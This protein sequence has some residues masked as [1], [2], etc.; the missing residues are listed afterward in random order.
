MPA[1]LH[2]GS[3]FLTYNANRPE[4]VASIMV[5]FSYHYHY[6]G[7]IVAIYMLFFYFIK[8][9]VLDCKG[10]DKGEIIAHILLLKTPVL[11]L[12]PTYA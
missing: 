9:V 11:M 7:I 5:I 8:G 2:G 4:F 6:F 12:Y 1:S 10:K 3:L